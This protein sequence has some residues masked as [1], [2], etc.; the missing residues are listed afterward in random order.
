[1]K[2]EGLH[3]GEKEMKNKQRSK[4]RRIKP[5]KTPKNKARETENSLTN[6]GETWK[7]P[8]EMT[9]MSLNLS[10]THHTMHPSHHLPP[11][12]PRSFRM[13]EYSPGL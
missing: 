2:R 11:T 9:Q 4:Q 1:M 5:E 10:V 3:G 7:C 8:G 13:G 12:G 6:F